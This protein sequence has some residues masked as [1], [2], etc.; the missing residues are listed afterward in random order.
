MRFMP[1]IW[2]WLVEASLAPRSAASFPMDHMSLLPVW[3]R[4]CMMRV[5]APCDRRARIALRMAVMYGLAA[6]EVGTEFEVRAFW[7]ACIE[8]RLS[9]WVSMF[10]VTGAM[11]SERFI[12]EAS[13]R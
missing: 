11:R 1:S 3:A 8:L 13:A 12:A 2:A 6:A 10:T 9:V 7:M 5:V 4:T